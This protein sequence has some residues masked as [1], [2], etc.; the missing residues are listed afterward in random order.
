MFEGNFIQIFIYSYLSQIEELKKKGSL[1]LRSEQIF[2]Y[3]QISKN[4]HKNIKT[5]SVV[6][7]FKNEYSNIFQLGKWHECEYE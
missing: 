2:K 6:Q 3:I 7:K 1:M 4:I 5:Y